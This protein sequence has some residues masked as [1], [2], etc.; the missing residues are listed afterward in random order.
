MV[1]V[2]IRLVRD[3]HI[4]IGEVINLLNVLLRLQSRLYV[5]VSG[6]QRWIH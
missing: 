1:L 2:Q 3:V 6:I 5:H 4:Q